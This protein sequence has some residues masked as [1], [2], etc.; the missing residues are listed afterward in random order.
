MSPFASS[1]GGPLDQEDV[2]AIVA[3]IRSWEA[4][5]PVEV[6]PEVAQETLALKGAEIYQSICTQCHGAQGEGGVGP[7]L[8]DPKF[9]ADNTDQAMFDT[10]S[11]GHANTPMIAWG[12]VLSEEQ[13]KQLVAFIRQ[14]KAVGGVEPTPTGPVSFQKDVLPILKAQCAMCHGSLGG[15]DASSYDK[16]MTSGDNG[17]T[18]IPGDVD[19]SL[20]AQKILGTQPT[21]MIMPPGG[22]MADNLIQMILDWIKAGAPNN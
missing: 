13:I 17:P 3:Y 16:V 4:N 12:D 1:N 22:K 19:K 8:S 15:W 2:D 5:P 7:A 11:Q 21:G 10:I 6:P 18:V 14:L 9:Q 20:L